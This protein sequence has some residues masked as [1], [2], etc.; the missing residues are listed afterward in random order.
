MLIYSTLSHSK[1]PRSNK[2]LNAETG[3]FAISVHSGI[4]FLTPEECFDLYN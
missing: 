2:I 3:K 1:Y 4:A